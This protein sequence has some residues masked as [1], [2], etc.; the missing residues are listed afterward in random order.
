MSAM[1]SALTI[2]ARSRSSCGWLSHHLA[3]SAAAAGMG[4]LVVLG[5]RLAFAGQSAGMLQESAMFINDFLA[6]AKLAPEVRRRGRGQEPGPFGPITADEVTFS[7]PGSERVA[8]HD[9]SLRIEPGEVVAL[10]GANGSGKTTLAKLLAGLYLPV[11]GGSADPPRGTTSLGR[12]GGFRYDGIAFRR[13][14]AGA[15]V[16]RRDRPVTGQW[17]R[18][19]AF[20][21]VWPSE[22]AVTVRAA[23]MRS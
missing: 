7:Y 1:A 23:T 3:L 22:A 14:A 19:E 4:A 6:F 17:Q 10:V 13:D 20:R 5:G 11:R 12:H 18:L 8:L 21:G 16:H 15:R 2:A 9:V